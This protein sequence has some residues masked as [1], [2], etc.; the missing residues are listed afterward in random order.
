[1]RARK[2]RVFRYFVNGGCCKQRSGEVIETVR[3]QRVAEFAYHGFA[4]AF[5]HVSHTLTDRV[6]GNTFIGFLQRRR[7]AW[8][9]ERQFKIAGKHP[10]H[11][12]EETPSL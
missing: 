2:K 9:L 1:M 11:H 5:A 12:G 8:V 7:A 10:R 6:G 3:A 4:H